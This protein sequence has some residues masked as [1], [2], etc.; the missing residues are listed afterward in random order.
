MLKFWLRAAAIGCLIVLAGGA[1]AQA[2]TN[3]LQ[4]GGLE[5]DAFGPYTGRRGGEFPIYLPNGWNVWLASPTGDRYNRSERTAINPHPGPGP[6]PREGRRALNVDCGFFTCT[7]AIYQQVGG[8]TPGQN[9]QASAWAQVKAC[10]LPKDANGNLIGDN[11]G[12]AIESGAQTRIGI[13]P[14]GG[15]DPNDPDI[16]WSSY[17]APHEQGGWQQMSVSA[18]ATGDTVTLFLYST[19]TNFAD[20]NRTYWDDASLTGGGA[21]GAAPGQPAATLAPT[22]PPVVG[23]VVPQAPQDDGSIVHTVQAGDTVDSIAFAYGVTRTQILELNSLADPRIIVPGQ[24]L[25]IKPAAPAAAGREPAAGAGGDQPPAEQE[26]PPVEPPPAESAAGEGTN[27]EAVVETPTTAPPTHTPAPAPVT[28]VAS[29]AINPAAATGQVCVLL[30]NDRNQNRIQEVGEELLSGGKIALNQGAA[31]SYDTDGVSEPF[32]FAELAAG[33]YV[34]AASA[35]A[36]YGLTT[37]AQLRVRLNPGASVNLTFGAAEGV[38][39]ALPPPVDAG[40]LVSENAGP[41]TDTVSLTDQILNISGLLVF[42]LAG[43]VLLGGLGMALVLR[44]R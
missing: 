5:E 22:A 15:T 23:F 21:G 19:Q 3:L 41:E 27:F 44:R 37:P 38:R 8:I 34:A 6:S 36:G 32:C 28:A 16:V 13:D 9:V 10:D 12:S 24:K 42:G 30:F 29:S 18:T 14:N 2:Q 20:L 40:G 31:G 26:P 4:N 11:C 35:P 25:I 39:P 7:A 43:L 1:V 33:D 17:I